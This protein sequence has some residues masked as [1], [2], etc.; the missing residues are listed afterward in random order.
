MKKLTVQES[1]L[2]QSLT[3]EIELFSTMQFAYGLYDFNA[4]KIIDDICRVFKLKFVG[5]EGHVHILEDKDER[6]LSLLFSE[7]YHA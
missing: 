4:E 1:E 6:I 5:T 3:Q 7:E 2:D